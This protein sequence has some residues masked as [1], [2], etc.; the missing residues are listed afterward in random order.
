[1]LAVM[2]VT[3]S[4][5]LARPGAIPGDLAWFRLATSGRRLLGGSRTI[6]E[7]AGLGWRAG[8]REVTCLTRGGTARMTELGRALERISDRWRIRCLLELTD[9]E[10]VIGGAETLHSVWE[11]VD[12]VLL[13]RCRDSLGV[14]GLSVPPLDDGRWERVDEWLAD[15]NRWGLELERWRRRS[16]S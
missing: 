7:L 11:R 4:G 6:L 2:A 16:R 8:D 9:E 14:S 10:V 15:A 1:M 5:L 3:D 13:T 12:D